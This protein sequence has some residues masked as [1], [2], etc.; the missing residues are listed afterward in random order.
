MRRH[1]LHPQGSSHSLTYLH[2][3]RPTPSPD[4]SV[5]AQSVRLVQGANAVCVTDDDDVGERML[6]FLA[7]RT[8]VKLV[9]LRGASSSSSSSSSTVHLPT[10][11]AYGIQARALSVSTSTSSS[12]SS[13]LHL[14]PGVVSRRSLY[15][16]EGRR[17]AYVLH[18][19]P[20]PMSYVM[21]E[22]MWLITHGAH[23]CLYNDIIA[24][25]F[26]R[27][28]PIRPCDPQRRSLL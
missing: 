8:A 13:T 7:E 15:A 18:L 25:E 28:N 6:T 21:H 20:C 23:V 26:S 11:R 22:R 24:A 3:P 2:P 10:A 12:A 19:Q 9:L 4:V 5:R 16:A 27:R 17:E 1:Q 14:D